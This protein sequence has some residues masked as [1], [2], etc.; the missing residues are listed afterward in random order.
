MTD[1]DVS[2]APDSLGELVTEAVNENP[3]SGKPDKLHRGDLESEVK[4]VTDRFAN[5]T[6]EL[7]EGKTLLTPQLIAAEIKRTRQEEGIDRREPSTGAIADNLKRW[8][9]IG[10][11]HI[12]DDKPLAFV[13][14]TDDA[15]AHGL[16]ALKKRAWNAK[17]NER[18]L[19][20]E[21]EG[22]TDT[23]GFWEPQSGGT[24]DAA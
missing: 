10:F 11:A 8:D 5:G 1:V 19:V 12:T 23:D 13:G 3:E 4:R 24:V 14:Y 6:F 17:A 21:G 22:T 9:R 20:P 18:R 15:Y 2:A 16:P 7:P